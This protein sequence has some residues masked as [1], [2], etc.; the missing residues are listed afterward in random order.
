MGVTGKSLS[1]A[2]VAVTGS[3]AYLTTTTNLTSPLP[4]DDELWATKSFARVNRYSN[5]SLQDDARKRIPLSKVRP[6]LRDDEEALAIEF[7]RGAWA[8][9]AYAPQ[10]I[11]MM[12]ANKGPRTEGQL[13]GRQQLASSNYELGT[14]FS[15]HFEVVERTSNSITVRSGGSPSEPG[16]REMDGLCVVSA[17]VDKATS[18]V[19]VSLKSSFFNSKVPDPDGKKLLPFLVELLHRYYARAMVDSGARY[20]TR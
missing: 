1:T 7:C 5:P 9:Y 17:K 3:V 15:D 4:A 18:T 11:I 2:L 14:R 6:E 20:L 16:P 19:D 8:G 10:R 13:F 12:L